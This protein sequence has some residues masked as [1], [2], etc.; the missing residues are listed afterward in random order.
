MEQLVANLERDPSD[1]DSTR[2]LGDLFRDSAAREDALEK[3][4]RLTSIFV[5]NFKIYEAGND[6]EFILEDL[7]VVINLLAD[8]DANRLSFI[9]ENEFWLVI[10]E[11]LTNIRFLQQSRTELEHCSISSY[12]TVK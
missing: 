7:R 9:E 2:K 8:N 11:I 10:K 12:T 1:L 4:P 3:I 6:P 5:G